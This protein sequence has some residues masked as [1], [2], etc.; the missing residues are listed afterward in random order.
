MTT[1]FSFAQNYSPT[2][3]TTWWENDDGGTTIY[4]PDYGG[5]PAVAVMTP[6]GPGAVTKDEGEMKKAME[7]ACA[8]VSYE[9]DKDSK[10]KWE[11]PSV[12]GKKKKGLWGRILGFFGIKTK[13]KG[14]IDGCNPRDMEDWLNGDRGKWG[15]VIFIP[16]FQSP[17]TVSNPQR[18]TQEIIRSW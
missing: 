10:S 7:D 15:D 3:G 4:F 11:G 17:R 12:D 1:Q 8:G 5:T 2:D 13:G 14:I 9:P 18:H 16:S 6:S